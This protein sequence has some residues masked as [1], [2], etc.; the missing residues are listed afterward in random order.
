M[1]TEKP[2]FG[3]IATYRDRQV[4]VY[5]YTSYEAQTKAARL[6]HARKQYEVDVMLAE[7]DGEPVEHVPLM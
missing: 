5:A 1:E 7:K 4:E 3:Y 2:R 6:L